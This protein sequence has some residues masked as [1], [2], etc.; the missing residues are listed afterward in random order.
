MIRNFDLHTNLYGSILIQKI[1]VNRPYLHF[2]ST[3]KYIVDNFMNLFFQYINMIDY[4]NKLKIKKRK[5]PGCP[6]R[7]GEKWEIS[8]DL[9][10]HLWQKN[11]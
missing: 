4:V 11:D 5:N 6:K 2:A 10:A 7:G 3:L 1:H 8:N 9:H